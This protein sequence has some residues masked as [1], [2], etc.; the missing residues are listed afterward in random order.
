MKYHSGGRDMEKKGRIVS[1]TDN[2]VREMQE[3]G[4][5]ESDW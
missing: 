5:S 1:Y 4:E 2:E 3:R